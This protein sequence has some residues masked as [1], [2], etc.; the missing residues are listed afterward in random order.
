MNRH[1]I[2]LDAALRRLASVATQTVPAATIF[3]GNL[4]SLARTSAS[5][6]ERH[7]GLLVRGISLGK[8][9]RGNAASDGA[10]GA[11]PIRRNAHLELSVTSIDREAEGAAARAG[12]L[13]RRR[14]AA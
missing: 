12:K 6:K 1:R 2:D 7:Y 13:P 10:G 4:P 3:R 5:S 8:P 11:C 14:A 9:T